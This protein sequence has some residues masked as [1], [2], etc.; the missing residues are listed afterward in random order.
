MGA[1]QF[2]ELDGEPLELVPPG[3]YDLRFLYHETKRIFDRPKLFLW[4]SIITFGDH[5]EKRIPRYYGATRLIGKPGKGGRFKVGR[6]GDFLREFMTLFP[7]NANR[8]DRLPMSRYENVIIV[9]KVRTV[10]R[11]RNQRPIPP[12][13]QYSVVDQLLRV[14]D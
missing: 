5:F 4:F 1:Q 2:A 11:G 8:L 6:K 12:E 10:E 7:V 3:E 14:K 9:G 13:A